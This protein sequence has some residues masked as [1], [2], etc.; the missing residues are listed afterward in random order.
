[1]T[2]PRSPGVAQPTGKP[3]EERPWALPSD[4]ITSPAPDLTL[5]GARSPATISSANVSKCR[6]KRGP[7]ALAVCQRDYHPSD[8]P[9]SPAD[10]IRRRTVKISGGRRTRPTRADLAASEFLAAPAAAR[11]G[12]T[13]S[14]PMIS[15]DPSRQGGGGLG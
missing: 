8:V 9:K 7:G 11:S 12:Q 3:A 2:W 4:I 1:M 6:T 10:L 5:G 14:G 15:P 13:G